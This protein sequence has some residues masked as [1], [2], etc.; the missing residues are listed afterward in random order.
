MA[1]K[2]ESYATGKPLQTR[3]ECLDSPRSVRALLHIP[4]A[5][6]QRAPF[7]TKS[8]LVVQAVIE[9]AEQEYLLLEML[10]R[11][12]QPVQIT[13]EGLSYTWHNVLALKVPQPRCSR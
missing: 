7:A 8:A 1:E 5:V 6:R 4:G 10:A 9:A 11:L 2:E 3:A 13:R 12:P